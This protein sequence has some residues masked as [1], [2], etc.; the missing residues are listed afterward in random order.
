MSK[1]ASKAAPKEVSSYAQRDIV[2]G[3]VRGFPPW[4]GMVVDPETVPEAVQ[5][6]RPAK[7]AN[8]Y[9]VQ[10]FPA[11]DYAWLVAKDI[12]KL[13]THEIESY[14]N[15]PY[16]KSGELLQGYRT[17]LDP[18]SWEATRASALASALASPPSHEDEVDELD[19]DDEA[20]RA[21]KTTKKRKRESE[22]AAAKTRKPPQAK[23]EP[24]EPKEPKAPKEKK[25]KKAPAKPR[26]SK[27]KAQA[28]VES[29]DEHGE[30]EDA[31][32]EDAGPS[33]KASPPPAKRVKRDKAGEKEKEE[34]DEESKMSA[35]SEALKVREWRHRLQKAF[36]SSKTTPEET[37]MPALDALFTTVEQHENMTVAYLQFSKI[38]KVMRHITL[39]TED[40]V[41]LD[42]EYRFRERARALVE[43]WQLVLGAGRG[44]EKGEKEV[45][46][47]GGKEEGKE[48]GKDEGA[49]TEAEEGANG[50]SE[51]GK[52]G[53]DLNGHADADM[54]GPT[55]AEA[56]DESMADVDAPGEAEVVDAQEQEQGQ[57]DATGEAEADVAMAEVEAEA[58]ADAE[59]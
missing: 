26:K 56:E 41:P 24:K 36:L 30:E 55:K 1:K 52:V 8:F 15:E 4:P 9:C 6:E 27:A 23:K 38:G 28:L 43:R 5:L 35:D 11:G 59:I 16:K 53:G 39:L 33:K 31:E 44:G 57:A 47:G 48:E 12:S 2:L 50:V 37:D 40:R 21:A 34:G 3:K 10:F 58:E 18:T 54:P 29:E 17:A 45:N 46:G 49:G 19:T 51:E 32:G 22:P 7:K 25:E 13:Q 14:I 42:G 20:K